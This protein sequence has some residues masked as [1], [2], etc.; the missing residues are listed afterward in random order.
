[1][2]IAGEIAGVQKIEASTRLDP[3]SG[4]TIP[5]EKSLYFKQIFVLPII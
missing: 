3:L 2:P 4:E 5:S 1:M